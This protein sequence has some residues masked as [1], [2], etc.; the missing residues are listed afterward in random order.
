M[1]KNWFQFLRTFLGD[2][3][4]ASAVEYGLIVGLIAVALIAVL[5]LVGGD[6]DEEGL[7]GLFNTVATEV[8]EATPSG[9]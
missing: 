5:L 8:Q 6:S 7:R 3:E 2:E 4:G 1:L 9:D